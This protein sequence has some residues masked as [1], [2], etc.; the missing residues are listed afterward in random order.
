MIVEL[1]SYRE[2]RKRDDANRS[3]K[4]LEKSISQ[5]KDLKK[6]AIER[7]LNRARQRSW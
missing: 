1:K 5:Q 2:S 4:H 7:S 3:N 6:E